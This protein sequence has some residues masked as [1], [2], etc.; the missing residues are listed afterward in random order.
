MSKYGYLNVFQ[1]V[2][3]SLRQR[4]LTVLH[5]MKLI[6]MYGLKAQFSILGSQQIEVD[7]N[8]SMRNIFAVNLI[9]V[10]GQKLFHK[11]GASCSK[12]H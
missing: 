2:P 5:M 4:K 7:I 12:H 8:H 3:W 10:S 6:I 1:K 9:T 11:T